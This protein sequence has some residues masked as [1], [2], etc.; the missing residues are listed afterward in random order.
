MTFRPDVVRGAAGALSGIVDYRL[1]RN[2]VIKE[3]KKGRLTR[4]DVCDAHPELV[5]NARHCGSPTDDPCPICESADDLVVVTYVFGARMPASGRC[6]L[7]AAE[8]ARLQRGN[9]ELAAYVVECCRACNWNH[10]LRSFPV[11]RRTGR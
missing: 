11:G 10:L 7:S 3:F 9:Q 4:L 2:G 1:T 6:M 5:R 8:L